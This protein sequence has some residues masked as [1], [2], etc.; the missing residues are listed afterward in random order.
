VAQPF[1]IL[2]NWIS[3]CGFFDLLCDPDAE[4]NLIPQIKTYSTF[5]IEEIF[6]LPGQEVILRKTFLTLCLICA[7]QTNVLITH[8]KFPIQ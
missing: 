3:P 5:S 2:S 6:I 1:F 4:R 8:E 7:D